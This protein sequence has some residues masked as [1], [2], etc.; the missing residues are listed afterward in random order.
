MMPELLPDPQ[1]ESLMQFAAPKVQVGEEHRPMNEL[2][3]AT[4][5]GC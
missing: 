1:A 3:P 4:G 5:S 2:L